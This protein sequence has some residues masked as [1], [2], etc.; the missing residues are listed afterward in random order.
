MEP[1]HEDFDVIAIYD[2]TPSS[3]DN[4]DLPLTKGQIVHIVN[5]V[6]LH[7]WKARNNKGQE[8]YVPSNYVKKVG[9]ETEE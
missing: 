7:W 2:F 3:S 1:A 9:V 6:R 8:G 5:S 4:K